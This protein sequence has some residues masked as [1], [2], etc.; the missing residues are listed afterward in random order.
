MGETSGCGGDCDVSHHNRRPRWDTLTPVCP[1]AGRADRSSRP[2]RMPSRTPIQDQDRVVAARARLR[3]GPTRISAHT[4]IPARTV[5]RIL[6]RRDLP[7][8]ADCDPLTGQRIRTTRYTTRRYE[9]PAPGD[10]VHL[11]VKKIG[12]IPPGG[13]WRAHGRGTRPGRVRGVRYDYVHAAIDHHSRLA[14]AEI[15]DDERGTTCAGFLLR[16]AAWFASN[17]HSTRSPR[18][19]RQRQQLPDL[20]RRRHRHRRDRRPPQHHQTSSPLAERHSGAVQPHPAHRMGLPRRLPG[21]HHPTAALAPW[22][23]HHNTQRAHTA[24][25]AHPPTS[26]TQP[27]T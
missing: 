26:R 17:G 14:Y 2:H 22:L 9:H 11:D 5:S 23:D 15:L 7:R 12:K 27:P 20:P 6:A 18:P 3:C 10:L 24:L 1:P 25:D 8:L 16:A 13:G 21:Q 4:G 19:D